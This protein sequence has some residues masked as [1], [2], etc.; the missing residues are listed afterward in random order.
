MADRR[1]FQGALGQRMA[2][3]LAKVG[4]GPLGG[5]GRLVIDSFQC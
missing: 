1:D 5:S 2:P 4:V 3:D